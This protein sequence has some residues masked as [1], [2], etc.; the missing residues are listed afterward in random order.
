[1]VIRLCKYWEGSKKVVWELFC[2]LSCQKVATKIDAA[3]LYLR[4]E[5]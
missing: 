4:N 3:K 1:M 5:I 2:G